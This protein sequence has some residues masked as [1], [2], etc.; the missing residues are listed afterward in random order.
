MGRYTGAKHRI[1]RRF[2]ENIWGY[3]KTPLAARPY[4]AGQ[5]GRDGRKKKLSTYGEGL[6]EKQ[7]L[8]F[9]YQLREASFRRIFAKALAMPGN[10]GDNMMQMLERRLDNVVYRLGFAL[11]PRAARQLVAHG[12]ISVNGRKVDR[13]SYLVDIGDK[14]AIREKSRQHLQVQEAVA[15][16]AQTPSY[17]QANLEKFEG[18]LIQ[19]PRRDDIPMVVNERAVV[20]FL[21][22]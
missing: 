7:K 6:S 18:E 8:K 1:T 22:R 17:L 3:K 19:I 5:H 21:S 4:K 16:K 20:E 15:H 11:T 9:Y 14:V 10:T 2:A 12:H 13:A